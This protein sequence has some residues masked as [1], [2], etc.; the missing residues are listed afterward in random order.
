M[1]VRRF[2]AKLKQP[3]KNLLVQPVVRRKKS[4]SV[5][6]VWRGGKGIRTRQASKEPRNK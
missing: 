5:G 3:E 1:P 6:K 2:V 4:K